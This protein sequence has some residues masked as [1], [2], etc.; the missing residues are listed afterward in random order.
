MKRDEATRKRAENA[1]G[2]FRNDNSWLTQVL[3]PDLAHR[4]SAER[5][6]AGARRRRRAAAHAAGHLRQ[7]PARQSGRLHAVRPLR[8]TRGRR[9]DDAED[10]RQWLPHRAGAQATR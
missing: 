6:R 9:F 3:P 8:D 4:R 10:L 1:V 5:S 2:S 7:R